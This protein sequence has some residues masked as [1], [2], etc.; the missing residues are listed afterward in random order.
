MF[1]MTQTAISSVLLLAALCT[2]VH[3]REMEAGSRIPILNAID[4][5]LSTAAGRGSSAAAI[6]PDEAAL[7]IRDGIRVHTVETLYQSGRQEI[8]VLLPDSYRKDKSYRV[9][10]VLPVEKGFEQRYGYGLGVLKAMNAH[11]KH[12]LI[13]VQMGFEKGTVVWG[14][15]H[16][17]EDTAGQLSKGIRGSLHQETLLDRGRAGRQTPARIQQERV[18]SFQ[19]DSEVS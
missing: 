12:D 5:L 2:P 1:C 8:H 19:S 14:P 7:T 10:Y 17:S 3:P 11:N 4:E 9:V 16:E 18:G 6:N 13:I 15:C